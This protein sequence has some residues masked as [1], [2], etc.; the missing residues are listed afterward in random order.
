MVFR[1]LKC[2]FVILQVRVLVAGESQETRLGSHPP[3]LFALLIS[4]FI[5]L[6]LILEFKIP[7][8]H[9]KTLSIIFLSTHL[10]FSF[11]LI[12]SSRYLSVNGL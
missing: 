4:T 10:P 11:F 1:M 7:K 2:S 8:R 3:L 12:P 9:R 6:F 5:F